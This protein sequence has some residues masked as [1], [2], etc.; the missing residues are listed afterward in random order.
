MLDYGYDAFLDTISNLDAYNILHGG[1]GSN[2]K[3]ASSAAFFTTQTGAVIGFMAMSERIPFASWRATD[4]GGGIYAFDYNNIDEICETIADAKQRCDILIVSLHWGV[5][6][7]Y[8]VLPKQESAAKKMVDAGAD[9]IF[10]HHPHLLQKTELYN[11]RPIL[12]SAGNYLFFK[13]DD[14][15]GESAVFEIDIDKDGLIGMKYHPT[16]TSNCRANFLDEENERAER[17]RNILSDKIVDFSEIYKI[18]DE[19]N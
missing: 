6:Y 7:S 17:I 18:I 4:T 11:N 16:F 8:E 5:E 1:A 9:V 12:Y 2:K 15:A 10:G 14:Y 3:E 19:T 13:R